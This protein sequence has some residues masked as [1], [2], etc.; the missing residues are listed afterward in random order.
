MTHNE[1][2]I[3]FLQSVEKAEWTEAMKHLEEDFKFFGPEPDP[4][5]KETWLEFQIAL[6][7]AIPDWSFNLTEVK[8]A[9][10]CVDLQVAISGTHTGPLDLPLG[11][12][13]KLPA[14]QMKVNMPA[15]PV[16][17]VFR[18]EKIAEIHTSNKLQGGIMGVLGLR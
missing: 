4:V 1:I 17:L 9:D 14:T 16:K 10:S 6:K 15:E 12:L 7:A 2:A 8:E 13:P 3:K 5:D 18:G 11:R